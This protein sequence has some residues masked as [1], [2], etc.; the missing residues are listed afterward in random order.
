MLAIIVTAKIQEWDVGIE[1]ADKVGEVLLCL[2]C[3][4]RFCHCHQA[5][6]HEILH[7]MRC[8][9]KLGPEGCLYTNVAMGKVGRNVVR[10]RNVVVCNTQ[11]VITRASGIRLIRGIPLFPVEVLRANGRNHHVQSL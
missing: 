10:N 3:P 6:K 11:T 9:N 2:L 5:G 7:I 1:T 4:S 8:T